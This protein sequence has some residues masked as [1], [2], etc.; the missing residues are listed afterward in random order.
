MEHAPF[1]SGRPGINSKWSQVSTGH[2]L[3]EADIMN[4]QRYFENSRKRDDGMNVAMS[5]VGTPS[6]LPPAGCSSHKLHNF[7]QEQQMIVSSFRAQ[8]WPMQMKLA[9]VRNYRVNIDKH[10]AQLN[11]LDKC[12]RSMHK[13]A[14]RFRRK[15]R[16]MKEAMTLWGTIIKRIEGQS[17]TS[18]ASFFIFLRW[19]CALNCILAILV[20]T[21]IILPQAILGHGLDVP[22]SV[23]KN[24]TALSFIL[25]GK[26][27]LMEYSVLF[28]G[29]YDSGLNE[30]YHAPP[31]NPHPHLSFLHYKL[32][33]AYVIIMISLF[34]IYCIAILIKMAIKY[35]MLQKAEVSERFPFSWLVFNSWD[36]AIVEPATATS[37]MKDITMSLKETLTEV[38][39]VEEPGIRVWLWVL[40]VFTNTLVF[41]SLAGTS[42]AI[43]LAVDSA[44]SRVHN[45]D[46]HKA[47]SGGVEGMKLFLASFMVQGVITAR[48]MA[49]PYVFWVAEWLEKFHPRTALKM[50]LVRLFL[51]YLS[52]L[53]VLIIA[54]FTLSAQCKSSPG[55]ES[56]AA[57][58]HS[59]CC[60]ENIIG[61]EL[62]KLNLTHMMADMATMGLDMSR[63]I[64]PRL[65]MMKKTE[66]WVGP[67][68][69]RL[70]DSVLRLIYGQA[71]ILLGVLFCPLLPIIGL[72]KYIIIFYCR[73]MTA[74]Y[75]N[76]PPHNVFRVSSTLNFYMGILLA[77]VLLCSFPVGYAL[78]QITPSETCGPFRGLDSMAHVVLGEINNWPTALT[79]AIDNMRT[80]TVIIPMLALLGLKIYFYAVMSSALKEVNKDLKLQLRMEHADIRE[81]IAQH[82]NHHPDSDT[83]PP[84]SMNNTQRHFQL[85]H[86]LNSLQT[87]TSH[88][89]Q[90]AAVPHNSMMTE[91]VGHHQPPPSH[92]HVNGLHDN[93]LQVRVVPPPV[94]ASTHTHH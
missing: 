22:E 18:V 92:P 41:L 43:Y 66:K 35:K 57:D 52:S 83:Q 3:S 33:L 32:P 62:F 5:L 89:R 40:R 25:D 21:F 44:E 90:P 47:F 73:S 74:Y 26:G 11:I 70:A 46:F 60:W 20:L 63:W 53:Y 65:P 79:V 39:T 94:L 16:V 76:K 55:G 86:S 23:M 4:R 2:G 87:M 72:I 50:K 1:E 59:S 75:C 10:V 49:L 56:M 13:V 71:L 19:L 30:P 67:T 81:K 36:F 17:G 12:R 45:R 61:Q 37:K 48:N 93:D 64:L 91:H 82:H 28:Y 54:L 80:A 29:Y 88:Q 34:V 8:P 51:L 84:H 31:P 69:F 77:T 9:A 7:I 68:E 78:L 24:G 6:G 15:Y 27:Y 42:Y 85:Q 14:R 38:N 58:D